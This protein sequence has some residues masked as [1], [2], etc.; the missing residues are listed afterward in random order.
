MMEI[1]NR[2][3]KSIKKIK[4]LKKVAYEEYDMKGKLVWNQYVEYTVVGNNGSWRDFM[5]IDI[6]K[7][8]NPHINID[9]YTK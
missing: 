9:R 2:Y 5:P 3:T 7:K 1:Q 6:F 8:L 4:D